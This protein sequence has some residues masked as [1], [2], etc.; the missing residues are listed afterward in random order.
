MSERLREDFSLGNSDRELLNYEFARRAVG[1][2]I[3]SYVETHDTRLEVL[4]T[5]DTSGES[6]VHVGFCIVDSRSAKLGSADVPVEEED[7][8]ELNCTHTG[9]P[10][11]TE[12]Q[13]L[14]G[15][16]IDELTSFVK[17]FSVEDS[18][19]YDTLNASIQNDLKVDIHQFYQADVKADQPY[20]KILSCQ[21]SLRD[22][23]DIGPTKCLERRLDKAGAKERTM[24]NGSS[25]PSIKIRHP[26]EP[27][28]PVIKLDRAASDGPKAENDKNARRASV[29]SLSLNAPPVD[30]PETIPTKRPS[31]SIYSRRPSLTVEPAD[32]LPRRPKN[33]SLWEIAETDADDPMSPSHD[34]AYL[35]NEKSQRP[36]RSYTFQ[37]PSKAS[38]LFKWI[39]VPWNMTSWV[40][41]CCP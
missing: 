26:S 1:I 24:V 15:L 17:S 25:K 14:K 33:V 41:V 16:L 29:P 7:P 30:M 5:I 28:Q 39:H 11:F 10:R 19:A 32:I 35:D 4:S 34:L 18:A 37:L 6:V 31:I 13:G 23:F 40:P 21:P 8:V 3:Y 27:E 9:A 20:T 2:K 12:E 36:Q 38:N 22:F